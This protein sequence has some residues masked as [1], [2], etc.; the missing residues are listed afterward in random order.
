M[1]MVAFVLT[2]V[3]APFLYHPVKLYPEA[4]DAV[5]LKVVPDTPVRVPDP[6]TLPPVPALN[7]T[8]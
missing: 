4:A 2:G 7:V 3:A 8:V 5:A 6:F 1:L